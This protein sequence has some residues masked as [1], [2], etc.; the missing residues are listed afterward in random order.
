MGEEAEEERKKKEEEEEVRDVINAF[1]KQ[2]RL[3][4]ERR[5]WRISALTCI[6]AGMSGG[7]LLEEPDMCGIAL[8]VCIAGTLSR[9]PAL[10]LTREDEGEG[11]NS[12][13]P[14]KGNSSEKEK[15]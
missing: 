5:V 6:A 12:N 1:L 7:I 14:A 2:K 3:R 10:A 13:T 8:F 11:E 15:E 9:L 4:D